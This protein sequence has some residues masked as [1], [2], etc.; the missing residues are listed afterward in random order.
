ME[1][2]IT[3]GKTDVTDEF[4]RYVR[5]LIGDKWPGVPM[6]NGLQRFAKFKPVFA[7]KKLKEYKPEAYE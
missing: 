5:P 7:D 4:I 2:W 1:K 6:E 3:P